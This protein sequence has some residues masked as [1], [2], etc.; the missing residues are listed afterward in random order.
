LFDQR[1]MTRKIEPDALL[2]ERKDPDELQSL[3]NRFS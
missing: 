1:K 2:K 3:P